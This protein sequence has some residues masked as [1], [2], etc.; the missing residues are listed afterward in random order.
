MERGDKSPQINF[1]SKEIKNVFKVWLMA[2]TNLTTK[3]K[4]LIEDCLDNNKI[5]IIIDFEKE[6]YIQA[7]ISLNIF[8]WR[9]NVVRI[10]YTYMCVLACH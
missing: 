9:G 1:L 7:E 6:V 10:I 4:E 5:H 3:I 2:E 8:M